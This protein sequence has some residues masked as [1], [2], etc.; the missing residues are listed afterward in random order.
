VRSQAIAL[1]TAIALVYLI[2]R[3]WREAALMVGAA[4]VVILPWILW[5]AAHADG[6]AVLMR[7]DYGSYFTWFFDGVRERGPAIIL[8][9]LRRNVPDMFGHI[10][11][12]LRPP[13][14]PIPESVASLCVGLLGVLGI[15]RLVRRAPVTVAFLG[16]Y[17]AIVAVW[18]FA[19]VRFLLGIWVLLMLVLAAGVE[20]L[21]EGAPHATWLGTKR[22]VITRTAAALVSIVLIGGVVAY[23]V[24][25]YQR[26][27]WATTEEL[28]A[29]W[30]AP[31]L[32]WVG[33]HTDSSAVIASDHDEGTIYLYTGRH[34]VP[35]TTFTA[36]EYVDPRP[37][38]GDAAALDAFIARFKPDY[39]VLSSVRL[40]PAAAAASV[41]G[42][43]L[44]DGAHTVVPWA[45]TLRP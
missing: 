36:A 40:R 12:R 27:W 5:T 1:I 44:G 18:P 17:L 35:V 14:N 13:T 15:A 26:R 43:P 7:G 11:H 6:V 34:T 32:A 45:F 25:G 33:S 19:P 38:E 28:S 41:K 23:N 16:G 3:R 9:T 4:M 30:I 20:V 39:L 2:R 22:V 29:R 10:T 8:E 42:V 24:R 37:V 31:K 21:L